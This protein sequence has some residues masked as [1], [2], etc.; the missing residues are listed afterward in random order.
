MQAVLTGDIV[1]ST[2]LSALNERKLIKQLEA[3]LSPYQYEFY[4]GDSFQVYLK[5]AKNALR[6][7]MLCRAAAIK[8][9][10]AGAGRVNDVRLSIGIGETKTSFKNLSTAKGEPFILSGRAFDQISKSGARLIILTREN[11]WLENQSMQIIAQYADAV[12]KELTPKQ[13]SVIFELLNGQNQFAAAK[14]LKKSKSTVSQHANSGRWI[15]IE[16]LLQHFE[17]IIE[18]LL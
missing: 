2:L 15:E 14:R 16:R 10:Q 4:R 5:N 8:F 7:S 18:H 13:A 12:F 11:K 9:S 3:V 6:T 1:N 17:N